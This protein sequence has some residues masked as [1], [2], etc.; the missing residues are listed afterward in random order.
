MSTAWL[1]SRLEEEDTTEHPQRWKSIVERLRGVDKSTMS[2]SHVSSTSVDNLQPKSP[3][4]CRIQ[5][6][7]RLSQQSQSRGGAPTNPVKGSFRRDVVSLREAFREPEIMNAGEA[8]LVAIAASLID[9]RHTLTLGE[10]KL[11]RDVA[12][13]DK[14][15]VASYRKQIMQGQDI[16]GSEFCKVR[17]AEKRRHNG[18]TYTPPPI[19]D[20]MISWAASVDAA[21]ERIVDPGIGSGRFMSAAAERFPN[22]ELV[23]IDIDPLALLMARANACVQGY[24]NR[25]RLEFSDYRAVELA[26]CQGRTLYI[27]N[28]P[29]VRHHNISER[30]KTW[31]AATA[32]RFGFKASKLAGL[33][34]HFFLRT[35]E[36]AKHGDYGAFIT[37]AEWL[38]VNYGSTLRSMLADGLGGSAVHIIDPKAQPFADA[39]TTGA[40]TCFQ[41]G[42]RPTHFAVRA[43]HDLDDLAPLGQGRAVDWEEMAKAPRWSAFTRKQNNI[44]AGFIELGELFRVHRGQVTGANKAWIVGPEARDVPHRYKRPTITKGRELLAIRTELV[45]SV[46]LK[47]VVDLPIAFDELEPE[48]RKAVRKFLVWAKS[49]GAEESYVAQH[50]RSWWAIELRAPAPVLCTYMARQAPAFVLNSARARHLNIAHGLY[51]RSLLDERTLA[52]ILIW[53]RRHVGTSGGRVYAG[54]L[55]KFE[56]KE[57]ERIPI[58]ALEDIHAAISEEMEQRGTNDGRRASGRELQA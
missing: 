55:V 2:G 33:H 5:F 12:A 25:L 50:R 26:P 36:I 48:E 17:S 27:G 53:L 9:R 28:P 52:A 34:I 47:K 7:S 57:L 22:A 19:V 15:V 18:A 30:W 4:D 38:D 42:N 13:V 35:R 6:A 1:L 45:T 29:Y 49:V 24:A 32:H 20:A 11:I 31:F 46:N 10:Q 37:A 16:L 8:K 54:G 56:P 44:P 58:P 39:F 43:V 14:S 3:A 21:P 23:G 41:V 51:P 40:V